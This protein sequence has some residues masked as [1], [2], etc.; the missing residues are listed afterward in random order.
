MSK[1]PGPFDVVKS[2]L[3]AMFGVQ[4]PENRERDFKHGKATHFI[5]TGIILTVIFVLVLI[6]LVSSIVEEAGLS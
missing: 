4:S 2:V 1:A 3:A 5:V 6:S